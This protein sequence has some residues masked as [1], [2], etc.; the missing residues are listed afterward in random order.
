M[1]VYEFV[2]KNLNIYDKTTN[3][4][5]VVGQQYDMTIKRHDEIVKNIKKLF[6]NSK[7]PYFERV[8]KEEE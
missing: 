1:A 8:K 4:K 6:P 3:E 7:E 5:F 2:N